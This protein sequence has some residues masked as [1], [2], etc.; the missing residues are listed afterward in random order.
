MNWTDY[1]ILGVLALSVLVGLW[2]GLV[3]E[4]LALVI[5]IA[6]FWVAWSF[7]PAVARHFEHVI[8]L[9]ACAAPADRHRR[10]HVLS[11]QQRQLA[12]PGNGSQ[13]R[14]RHG[15]DGGL[16]RIEPRGRELERTSIPRRG[17]DHRLRIGR[18]PRGID[19][20][21]AKRQLLKGR[22]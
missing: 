2:R 18:E 1:I 12:R 15:Q 5:W 13:S 16:R 6:A 3:S 14:V 20:T 21:A 9:L 10:Q 19:V 7:G 11:Q 4:V 8:E 22:L 17:C